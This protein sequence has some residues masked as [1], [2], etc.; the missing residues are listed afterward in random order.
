MEL[1]LRRG[2][3]SDVDALLCVENA[4]YSE[5]FSAQTFESYLVN[6]STICVVAELD[7][8]LVGYALATVNICQSQLLSIAVSP[9][10]RSRGIARQLLAGLMSYCQSNGAD[11]IRLEVRSKNIPARRLYEHLGFNLIGLR[12]GYYSDDDALVMRAELHLLES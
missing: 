10:Y 9:H 5:P 1:M 3:V 11:T 4:S 7:A 2:A 6:P 8:K 12:N